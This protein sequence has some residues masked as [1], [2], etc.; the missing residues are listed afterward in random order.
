VGGAWTSGTSIPLSEVS[1]EYEVEIMNGSTVV[2]TVTGLTSPAYTYSA[3]N[4]TT[5]F[6]SGQTTLTFRVYQ[7]SDAVGRGF[8]ASATV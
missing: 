4:Q 8:V 3:A 5:D 7:I 2:R 6:G 1:E